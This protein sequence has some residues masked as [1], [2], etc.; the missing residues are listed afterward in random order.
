MYL[1]SEGKGRGAYS[2]KGLSFLIGQEAM[3]SI[4]EGTALGQKE[5]QHT[6]TKEGKWDRGR[7]LKA[8]KYNTC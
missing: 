5:I 2:R 7:G 4:E 3:C 1:E 8:G 6:H